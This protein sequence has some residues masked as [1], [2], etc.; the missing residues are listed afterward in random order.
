MARKMAFDDMRRGGSSFS[1]TNKRRDRRERRELVLSAWNS[2]FAIDSFS[3]IMA[4][5]AIPALLKSA[6][7]ASDQSKCGRGFC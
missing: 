3:A 4:L 2:A 6:L 7:N 5:T 1:T